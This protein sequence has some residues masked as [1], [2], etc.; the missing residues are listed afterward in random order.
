MIPYSR[1]NVI[2]QDIDAVS[3]SLEGKFLTNNPSGGNVREFEKALAEYGN[4][5]YCIAVN[6]G[7]SS[8]LCAL[9]CLNLNENDEVIVPTL[10]FVATANAVKLAGGKVILCDIDKDTLCIDVKKAEKL[11]NKNTKGII[12][13]DY[14]GQ[15]CDYY[16][17]DKLRKFY[18]VAIISDS[19]HGMLKHSET[20]ADFTC[21]SFH[22]VKHITTG[23]GGGILTN[24]LSFYNLMRAFSNHGKY[25]NMPYSTMPG[26]NLRMNEFQAALG[27]SQLKR[28]NEIFLLK[29]LQANYYDAYFLNSNLH[30]I[31]VPVLREQYH[32]N[33]L[34]VIKILPT[35]NINRDYV[36]KEMYKLGIETQIHYKPLNKLFFGEDDIKNCF[37]PV[38]NLIENQILSLPIFPGLTQKQQ[39]FIIKSLIEIIGRGI[40]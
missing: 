10:T 16:L 5:K 13:V 20:N 14:A 1:Q 15:S 36:K 32:T 21:Y 40:K 17:L 3:Q 23:E 34:Y 30:K 7:T 38:T 27:L 22:P 26:L 2:Q 9:K 19:C 29:N 4:S 39:D 25:T 8:L 18:N 12:A 37:F 35:K 24:N 11:I 31:I 33:H 28:I 6:S